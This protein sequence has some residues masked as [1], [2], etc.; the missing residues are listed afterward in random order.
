MLSPTIDSLRLFLHVLAATVWVGGQFTL[1]GLVPTIRGIS[2]GATAVVARQFARL[3]WPAFGVLLVTG[4]W[5]L[6]AVNPSTKSGAWNATFDIKMG[7]VVLAGASAFLHTKAKGKFGLA[8][9]GALS[10]VTS[11]AALYLGVLLAK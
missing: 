6:V 3:S 4:V 5:N 2:P 1:A 9:W 8:F 10:A 11:L 7:V